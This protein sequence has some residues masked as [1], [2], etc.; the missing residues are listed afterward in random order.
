MKWTNMLIIE[1]RWK[2]EWGRKWVGDRELQRTTET[3]CLLRRQRW[4]G[5][6]GG[7]GG[8]G[9]DAEGAVEGVAAVCGEREALGTLPAHEEPPHHHPRID[10]Q[11]KGQSRRGTLEVAGEEENGRGESSIP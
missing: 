9:E 1:S 10:S 11:G 2:G 5:H 4:R 8:V 3:S 7:E 6:D